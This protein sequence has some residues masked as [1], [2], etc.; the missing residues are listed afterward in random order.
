VSGAAGESAAP[1]AYTEAEA[2]AVAA[3]LALLD[4]HWGL[5]PDGEL[6]DRRWTGYGPDRVAGPWIPGR[7][8]PTEG[9]RQAAANEWAAAEDWGDAHDWRRASYRLAG[10]GSMAQHYGRWAD[11]NYLDDCANA[12]WAMTGAVATAGE[13]A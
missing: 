3:G 2:V 8:V 9:A 12:A 4:A 10:M 11:A 6:I 7:Y 1:T 5:A 13:G